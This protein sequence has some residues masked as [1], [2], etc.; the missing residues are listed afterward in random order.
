[1]KEMKIKEILMKKDRDFQKV[2]KLHKQCEQKLDEYM[3]KDWLSDQEEVM[4]KELK[5]KKLSLKDQMYKMIA[6]YKKSL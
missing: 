1:M 6:D 5:K 2:A 3:Q 4:E